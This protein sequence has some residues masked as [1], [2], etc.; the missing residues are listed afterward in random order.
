MHG[1]GGVD[2]FF[3]IGS[4]A[5]AFD[6]D[7]HHGRLAG[8]D[9]LQL[10]AEHCFHRNIGALAFFYFGKTAVFPAPGV[11]AHPAAHVDFD[12]E[13]GG[14]FYRY[15][16]QGVVV[17]ER[18]VGRVNIAHDHAGAFHPEEFRQASPHQGEPEAEFHP[19]VSGAGFKIDKMIF[20]IHFQ[21]EPTDD[22]CV[23]TDAEI[24][25]EIHLCFAAGPL[26]DAAVFFK[27]RRDL[28]VRP[29]TGAQ[30]RLETA[31]KTQGEQI[32]AHPHQQR[33]HGVEIHFC[34]IVQL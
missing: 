27:F 8:V 11:G 28:P 20:H 29:H 10:V 13:A 23:G 1:H 31:G 24:S 4:A 18:V 5:L 17:I 16:G 33:H 7:L 9:L 34:R 19:A 32:V 21:R 30:V 15:Q 12:R 6:L 25:S 3:Q 14:V 22:G 26:G 2:L